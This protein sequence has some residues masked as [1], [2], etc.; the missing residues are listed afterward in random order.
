MKRGSSRIFKPTSEPMVRISSRKR[1]ARS[2]APTQALAQNCRTAARE[3]ARRL[4]TG[5]FVSIMEAPVGRQSP[6]KASSWANGAA[7]M[8]EAFTFETPSR[9]MLKYSGKLRERSCR[10]EVGWPGDGG[11]ETDAWWRHSSR[12][13]VQVPWHGAGRRRDD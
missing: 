3:P 11:R 5:P 9:R 12:S 2:R 8:A 10:W 4:E 7:H 1:K 13:R 6:P